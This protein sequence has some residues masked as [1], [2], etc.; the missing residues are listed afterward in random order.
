[1]SGT[2]YDTVNTPSNMAASDLVAASAVVNGEQWI[3]GSFSVLHARHALRMRTACNLVL[4]CS[5]K[6]AD[7]MQIDHAAAP[8]ACAPHPLLMRLKDCPAYSVLGDLVLR[9]GAGP[10]VQL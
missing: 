1:M 3:A 9:P 8:Q 2:S 5:L 6:Y 7:S 10:D 4:R